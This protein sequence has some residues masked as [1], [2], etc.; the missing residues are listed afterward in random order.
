MSKYGN[1]IA[2]I[3]SEKYSA[4]MDEVP[5][6]REDLI[7]HAHKLGIAPPKN[8]GDIVYS[9]RYRADLPEAITKTVH[10]GYTLIIRCLARQASDK[11]HVR[12]F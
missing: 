2:S 5:F 1:I 11:Y 12:I 6:M 9:F 8:L 10:E 4:S 7:T 3:F